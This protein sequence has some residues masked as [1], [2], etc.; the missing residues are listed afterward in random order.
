MQGVA[1]VFSFNLKKSKVIVALGSRDKGMAE[2]WGGSEPERLE[3]IGKGLLS[4]KS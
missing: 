1:E 3:G 2:A 4:G